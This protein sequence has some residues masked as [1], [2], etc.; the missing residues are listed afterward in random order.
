MGSCLTCL[1]LVPPYSVLGDTQTSPRGATKQTAHD[2]WPGHESCRWTTGAASARGK[3]KLSFGEFAQTDTCFPAGLRQTAADGHT[4]RPHRGLLF[5]PSHC[6]VPGR[7][8]RAWLKAFT[9]T[10]ST[11]LIEWIDWLSQL[12]SPKLWFYINSASHVCHFLSEVADSQCTFH[13]QQN[14]MLFKIGHLRVVTKGNKPQGGQQTL[15]VQTWYWIFIKSN[16]FFQ[17]IKVLKKK[18]KS[19][20]NFILSPPRHSGPVVLNSFMT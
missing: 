12:C 15:Q 10:S 17:S 14:F 1:S 16:T 6:C 4:R 11:Y 3:R 18:K 8:S 20:Q 9:S 19:S 5:R 13:C 2:F 7:T